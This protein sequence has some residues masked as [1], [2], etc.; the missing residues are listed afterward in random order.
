MGWLSQ[1][2][3]GPF[4]TEEKH[5]NQPRKNKL[6]AFTLIE[7][8][9]VIAI[10]AIL[11]GML[12]PALAKAK[13]R[14]SRIKCVSNLKQVGLGFRI[15]ANENDDLY[16]YRATNL[17]NPTMG[18]TIQSNSTSAY[19]WEH[20]QVLSNEI[21]NAKII[22]CPA[23][24]NRQNT[25]A[26]DFLNAGT[27]T[28]KSPGSSSLSL[29]ASGR[30]NESISY[31]VGLEADESRPQSL[32]AGDRSMATS[33]GVACYT[34]GTATTGIAINSVG[35]GQV[36]QDSKWSDLPANNLHDFQGNICLGDGSVQQMNGTKL[37]DAIRF[38]TNAY[39]IN[40]RLLMFPNAVD[41]R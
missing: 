21:Q 30:R 16:P 6:G 4:T 2:L 35:A 9:V 15:F 17:R 28:P 13:A 24:R 25:A 20:F 31:F 38:A 33:E 27:Q 3:S 26:E 41:N 39:G 1:G 22:L 37:G 18:T 40:G 32:L 14:A 19:A 12:L 8:L 5:M 10:I 36:N 11:A 23:D 34:N 29:S 7:L